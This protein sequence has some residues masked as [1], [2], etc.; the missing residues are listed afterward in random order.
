MPRPSKVYSYQGFRSNIPKDEDC[1]GQTQE[2]VAATSK[3][4]A[5][6]AFNASGTRGTVRSKDVS[7]T[8]WP[9]ALEKCLAEPGV[10]FWTALASHFKSDGPKWYRVESKEA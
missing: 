6:R 2:Y 9:P 5:T 7:E 4:T 8:R 1:H 10:V 3:A